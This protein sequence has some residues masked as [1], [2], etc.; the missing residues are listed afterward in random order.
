M[1][2]DFKKFAL[3]GDVVDLA[4]GVIIGGAFGKIVTSL[5]N[6]VIMPIL[7][8]FTGKI[9]L[10]TLKWIISEGKGGTAELSIKYGQFLQTMIDFFLVAFSIFIAIK[11]LSSFRKKEE[12]MISEIKPS[13][14]ELLLA[15]I[16]DVL[17][18]K[19]N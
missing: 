18:E 14:E 12:E 11:A 4:V 16:R 19:N 7:G 5:V 17:K 10:T 8:I 2:E 6:D 9:N 13:N 1:L 15:E 3:K